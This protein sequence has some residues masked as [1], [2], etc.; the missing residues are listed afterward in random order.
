MV[1]ADDSKAAGHVSC[2]LLSSDMNH[3]HNDIQ[4]VDRE[5]RLDGLLV[6]VD[7]GE[8]GFSD[9]VRELQHLEKRIAKT[10]RKSLGGRQSGNG[11]ARNHSS[12]GKA[13]RVVD[14]S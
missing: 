5:E 4:S 12:L 14:R 11:R 13:V 7:V 10:I 8:R 9:V 6:L 2:G 3:R 1:P